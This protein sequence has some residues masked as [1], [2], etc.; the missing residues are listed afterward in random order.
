MRLQPKN[1]D[2]FQ[3]YK[4]RKP[5]WIKLQRDLLNDFS[6]ASV[7]IGTKATLPLLWLLS[8]EYDDGVIDAS[9]E[10]IAFRVHIDVKTVSKAID[11][12]LS[13]GFYVDLDADVQDCTEVYK[14][15]PREEKKREETEKEEIP[16]GIDAIAWGEWVQH[17]KE[18]KKTLTKSTKT[19]QL[20]FLLAH[21]DNHVAIINQSIQNGWAGLFEPKKQQSRQPAQS[22]KQQDAQKTEDGID[23]FLAARDKGFD[24]RNISSENDVQDCEVIER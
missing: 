20:N 22:Y 9:I 12:L 21:I 14:N 23:A 18:I 6:Y 1:W 11:E 10:E 4:D 3:Q 19:K 17:R 2:K 13:L 24:L 5:Q 7:Q 8:S 16:N 15:V